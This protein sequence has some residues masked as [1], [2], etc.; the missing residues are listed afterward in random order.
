MKKLLLILIALPMIG[1]GQDKIIF[2]NGNEIKAKVLEVGEN[3]IKYKKISNLE[4]PNYSALKNEIQ[5][6]KYKNGE[7]DF[8]YQKQ[9]NDI[10]SSSSE[11]HYKGM[12]AADSLH[13]GGLSFFAGLVPVVGLIRAYSVEES[14][15]PIQEKKVN[16]LYLTNEH[17]NAGYNKKAYR[18]NIRNAWIATIISTT[19]LII[20]SPK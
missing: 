12:L 10:I 9:L 2:L 7:E 11:F 3:K 17:F 14:L 20:L 13:Y 4:G 19:F 15:P 5:S 18:I 8:F 16:N 6:I 1:F